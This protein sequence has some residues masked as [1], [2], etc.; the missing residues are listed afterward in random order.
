MHGSLTELAARDDFTKSRLDGFA[1]LI[2]PLTVEQFFSEY[3][4]RKAF[5]LPRNREGYFD[6]LLSL[7][8]LDEIIGSRVLRQ[9]DIRLAKSGRVFKFEEFAK[10]SVANRNAVLQEFSAGATI[11]LEHLNRHHLPL[12]QLLTQCEADLHIPFRANVYLTPANS[13]GFSPHWDT[14][15][16]LVLQVAGSK[17]WSVYDSPLRLPHEEQ[18]YSP[19]WVKQA[20]LIRDVTMRPGDVLFL[21]RGYIHSAKCTDELSLHITIGMRSFTVR[22]LVMHALKKATLEEDGLRGVALFRENFGTDRLEPLRETLHNVVDKLDLNEALE[23]IYSSFIRQRTPSRTGSIFSAI[24]KPVVTHQSR[25]KVRR[26]CLYQV[27]RKPD[28]VRLVLDGKV[29]I[30]PPG[31]EP[32]INFIAEAESFSVGEL[33]GVEQESQ[34]ILAGRLLQEGLIEPVAH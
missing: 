19:D 21:P 22:D 24:H 3:W 20:S 29:V 2:A 30:F 6:S 7:E 26:S 13:Q 31:V 4:E 11:I 5:Y 27:F 10:D 8:Q 28:S 14:H 18:K 23:S 12:G 1:G 34:L 25:F 15:D 32:V 33:P 16:V 9:P 17:Q